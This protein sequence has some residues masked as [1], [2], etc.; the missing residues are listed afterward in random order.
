MVYMMYSRRDF[1]KLALAGLP[2][3]MALAE[4]DSKISGVQIGV[5]S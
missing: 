1:G 3:S 4:I 2:L 5:Q